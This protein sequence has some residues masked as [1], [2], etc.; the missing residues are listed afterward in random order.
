MAA[1][2]P[3]ATLVAYPGRARI[4]IGRRPMETAA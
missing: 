1:A 2:P 4:M 3:P